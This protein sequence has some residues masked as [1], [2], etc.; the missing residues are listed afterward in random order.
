[1]TADELYKKL[2]SDL[3]YEEA[4]NYLERVWK[5]KEKYKG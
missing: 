1:M 5:Y 2:T 4:R 3:K